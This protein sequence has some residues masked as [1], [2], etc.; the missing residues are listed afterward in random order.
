MEVQGF[1]LWSMKHTFCEEI[2]QNLENALYPNPVRQHRCLLM[3]VAPDSQRPFK[4][5][6]TGVLIRIENWK[7]VCRGPLVLNRRICISYPTLTVVKVNVKGG[8]PRWVKKHHFRR[9]GQFLP[10]QVR[11][12]LRCILRRFAPSGGVSPQ[13]F[14]RS[15][16]IPILSFGRRQSTFGV[17]T[18]FVLFGR[19]QSCFQQNICREKV[20]SRS[21][22]SDW[23]SHF[24]IRVALMH[25]CVW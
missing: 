16:T 13:L 10:P 14:R 20:Y 6:S 1:A 18:L 21:S 24:Q 4:N 8:C 15:N 25:L 22:I 7:F 5:Y 19:R 11:Q 3:D 9:G 12:R 23:H 17:S 2:R